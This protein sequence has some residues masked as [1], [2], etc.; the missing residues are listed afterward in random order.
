MP[1]PT[2]RLTSKSKPCMTNFPEPTPPHRAC[3]KLTPSKSPPPS[4]KISST[5]ISRALVQPQLDELSAHLT[6]V[7]DLKLLSLPALPWMVLSPLDP[8][9]LVQSFP[10]DRKD[11]LNTILALADTI[12]DRIVQLLDEPELAPGLMSRS[13]S[14]NPTHGCGKTGETS[15]KIAKRDV[16]PIRSSC[17][18]QS[19]DAQDKRYS[20]ATRAY[21]RFVCDSEPAR[22]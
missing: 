22:R 20:Y 8:T 19:G 9:T 13:P 18:V 5:Q 6:D 14:K 2:A 3:S 15:W 17:V 12:S 16:T 10:I 7:Q 21:A 4:C 11:R 1:E